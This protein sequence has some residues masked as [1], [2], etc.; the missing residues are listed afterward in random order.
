MRSQYD[1]LL[2]HLVRFFQNISRF[3]CFV[4]IREITIRVNTESEEFLEGEMLTDCCIVG[5]LDVF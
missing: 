2:S 3:R 5:G 1:L 4:L